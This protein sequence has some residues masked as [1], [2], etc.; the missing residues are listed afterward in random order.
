MPD[1]TPELAWWVMTGVIAG[2]L[3]LINLMVAIIGYLLKSGFEKLANK[4]DAMQDNE[5]A[6]QRQLAETRATCE[7]RHKRLDYEILGMKSKLTP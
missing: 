1:T 6:T 7:E 5:A 2:L 4:I 3:S